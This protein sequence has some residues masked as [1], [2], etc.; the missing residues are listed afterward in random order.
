[1]EAGGYNGWYDIEI[2]S[3]NGLFGN[4]YPDS[5][6]HRPAAEVARESVAKTLELWR[7]RG[8]GVPA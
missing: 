4:D 1:L 3:D 8:D 2:F 6:W 7:T 5:V